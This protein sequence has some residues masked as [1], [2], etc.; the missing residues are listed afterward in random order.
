MRFD[1]YIKQYFQNNLFRLDSEKVLYTFYDISGFKDVN[2][3]TYM[4]HNC[5]IVPNKYFSHIINGELWTS[6]HKSA[7]Y[8]I[9]KEG[10]NSYDVLVDTPH[11]ATTCMGYNPFYTN[12]GRIDF[13]KYDRT[14]D[15]NS[16][17]HSYMYESN[18]DDL[19]NID[20]IDENLKKHSFTTSLFDDIQI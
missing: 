2:H 9:S 5:M 1:F 11:W 6:T 12:V 8:I 20:T 10:T 15:P 14:T 16:M 19:I 7:N 4:N 18:Y 17:Q 3:W 13:N